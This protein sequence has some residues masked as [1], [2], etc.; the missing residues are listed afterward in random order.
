MG[1]DVVAER[2]EFATCALEQLSLS[3]GV[4]LLGSALS[5]FG[6]L[7]SMADDSGETADPSIGALLDIFA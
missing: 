1:G 3:E 4:S 2:L 5:L 7:Q 6:T